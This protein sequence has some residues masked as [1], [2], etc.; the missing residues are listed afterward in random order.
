MGMGMEMEMEME[1]KMEMEMEME[2]RVKLIEQD[3][4]ESQEHLKNAW[5]PIV[6]NTRSVMPGRCRLMRLS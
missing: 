5:R 3:R 4:R 2:M 6:R 1:M